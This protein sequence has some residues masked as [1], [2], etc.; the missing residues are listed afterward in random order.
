MPMDPDTN[1]K[2]S[3]SKSQ[4]SE[5][6]RRN[7]P[8]AAPSI[9][10]HDVESVRNAVSSGWISGRGKYVELF[11]QSFGDWL[12]TKNVVACSSGTSALH[13]ALLAS[14]VESGSEVIIPALSMGAIPFAVAYV[15]AKQVLVDS[16]FDT[17]NMNPDSVNEK[18]TSPMAPTFLP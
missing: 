10:D 1:D 12:G 17:W 14:G 11:E 13:L 5:Q 4:A 9:S 16:E 18:I 3:D 15:G 7:V 2:D 6:I 8:I